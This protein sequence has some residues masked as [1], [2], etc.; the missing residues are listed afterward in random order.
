MV[1]IKTLTSVVEHEFFTKFRV[2][3]CTV[4]CCRNDWKRTDQAHPLFHRPL[5]FFLPRFPTST[6]VIVSLRQQTNLPSPSMATWTLSTWTTTSPPWNGSILAPSME[7]STSTLPA[8]PPTVLLMTIVSGQLPPWSLPH[9]CLLN[10]A[11][12]K[13]GFPLWPIDIA[14]Y[15]EASK[16]F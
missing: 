7:S 15:R 1:Y 6:A 9:A 2:N 5:P 10:I 14:S 8:W 3:S 13:T 16:L 4:L 11:Y 12:Q